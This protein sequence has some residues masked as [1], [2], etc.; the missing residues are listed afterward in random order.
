M[1]WGH[2]PWYTLLY[3]FDADFGVDQWHG[4]NAFI[5]DGSKIY[6]TYFIN[7]RGDEAMGTLWSYLAHDRWAAKNCGRNCRPDTRKQSPI[8]GR[9]GMTVIRLTARLIPNGTRCCLP[10][11]LPLK[12]AS[13]IG[14]ELAAGRTIPPR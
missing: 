3:K 13:T 12:V 1:G 8:N 2:I 5:H 7:G 14:H 4:H 9:V 11:W 10:A 6:R